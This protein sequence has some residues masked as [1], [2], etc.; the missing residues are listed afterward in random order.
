MRLAPKAAARCSGWRTVRRVAAPPAMGFESVYWSAGWWG[1]AFSSLGIL[2]DPNHPAL[3]EFPNDGRSDWQWHDLCTGATT[4][5]LDLCAAGLRPIVQPVPDFHYNTRLAIEC[6][7]G[8]GSLLVCG[9]DLFSD[10]ARR[11][12]VRQL[13]CSLFHYVA[14]PKVPSEPVIASRVAGS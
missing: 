8:A 1:N 4:F 10:L 13:R 5:L 11:P 3:R 9:Y 6:K 7:V 12:A 2:C 14:G